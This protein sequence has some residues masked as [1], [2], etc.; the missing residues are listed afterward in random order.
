MN[1]DKDFRQL[2][3]SYFE[4]RITR[5]GE[6]ALFDFINRNPHN[7]SLFRAWEKEWLSAERIDAATD[8]QWRRLQVRLA[9]KEAIRPMIV[10]SRF[11]LKRVMYAAASVIFVVGIAL[12]AYTYFNA[13]SDETYF[14]SEVP[15]G[16]R[17]KVI[18][19][20]GSTVWLNSGSTLKYSTEFSRKNRNVTL[21]GEGYFEVMKS[22]GHPFTVHTN[23]YDVVVRG[24]K[25]NVSAYSDDPSISTTLI[26]GRVEVNYRDSSFVMSPGEEVKLIKHTGQMLHAKVNSQQSVLWTDNRMEY[27]D[28]T[29]GEL[30]AKLS[31]KFNVRILI[32]DEKLRNYRFR[33]SLR[34]DESLE[35]IFNALE[36]ITPFTV[37][38]KD[39]IIYINSINI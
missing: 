15:L 23:G 14:I 35:Q 7:L 1:K 18:L 33:V 6:K 25:F 26:E 11:T 19:A 24:T 31:R 29:F 13:A 20:D 5:V 37:E 10:R 17:S 9:T 12:G 21:E 4:G 39:Q 2:A 3:I 28:I 30:A 36:V 38:K 32:Q 22:D 27:D 8:E 16:E 34:N